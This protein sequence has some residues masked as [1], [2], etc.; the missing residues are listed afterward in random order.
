LTSTKKSNL[1][2]EVENFLPVSE[3]V[4]VLQK[5]TGMRIKKEVEPAL[6]DA[7]R[8]FNI[9]SIRYVLGSFP[10]GIQKFLL[11]V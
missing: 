9:L 6:V 11:V 5:M 1:E 10:V 3:L 4:F 7:V 8:Q 2:F